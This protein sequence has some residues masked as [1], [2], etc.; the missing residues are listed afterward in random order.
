MKDD[1][2]ST[3]L[4]EFDLPLG[5]DEG[6]VRMGDIPLVSGDTLRGVLMIEV[7]MICVLKS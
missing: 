1:T 6:T 3:R 7:S 5:R 2:E 4:S